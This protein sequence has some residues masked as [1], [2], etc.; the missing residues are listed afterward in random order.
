MSPGRIFICRRS[1]GRGAE[2]F[3]Q[4]SSRCPSR[5]FLEKLSRSFHHSDLLCHCHRNPLVQGHPILLSQALGSLL[6][7]ERK[8]Q[9]IGCFAHSF[10]FFSSSGGLT[11]GIPNRSQATAKS[12]RL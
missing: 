7:G 4:S 9:R 8:F 2:K 10:T 1:P 5:P 12:A 6:N 11:T 3:H